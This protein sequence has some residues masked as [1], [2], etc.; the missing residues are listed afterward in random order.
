M[1]PTLGLTGKAGVFYKSIAGAHHRT[2]AALCR[3]QSL[4]FTMPTEVEN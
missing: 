3:A 2:Q 4:S 1:Q